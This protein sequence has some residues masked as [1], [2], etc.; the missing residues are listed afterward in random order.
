MKVENVNFKKLDHSS[1]E[2]YVKSLKDMLS[3]VT[4]LLDHHD[5]KRVN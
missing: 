1:K 2:A 4:I 5:S 3:E